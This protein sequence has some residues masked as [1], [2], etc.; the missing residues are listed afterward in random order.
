MFKCFI[1]DATVVYKS[2]RIPKNGRDGFYMKVTVWDYNIQKGKQ[3][4]NNFDIFVEGT[5]KK[6]DYL[7][8]LIEKGTRINA[9]LVMYMKEMEIIAENGKK[10]VNIVYFTERNIEVR[11]EDEGDMPR[12]KKAD[13]NDDNFSTSNDYQQNDNSVDLDDDIPF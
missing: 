5:V 2:K 1:T 9:D 12:Y 11:R 3:M 4:P 8:P 13:S 7:Y 6:I 10:Q